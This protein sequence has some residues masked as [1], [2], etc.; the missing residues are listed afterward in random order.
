MSNE[1]TYV[2]ELNKVIDGLRQELPRVPGMIDGAAAAAKIAIFWDQGYVEGKR[3]EAY[4]KLDEL[5]AQAD[6]FVSACEEEC[7]MV[8]TVKSLREAADA[9][10][11]I[12]FSGLLG[13]LDVAA[14][15]GSRGDW[16]SSNQQLYEA[17][18]Q[19]LEGK[20]RELQTG[21]ASLIAA[22]RRC[23]STLQSHIVGGLMATGGLIL[24]LAGLVVAI[25]TG[26]TGIGA[27]IGLI[28]AIASFIFA[29]A[30]FFTLPDVTG[31]IR[32]QADAIKR[33]ASGID[34]TNWPPAP[35]LSAAGW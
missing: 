12:D 15:M 2:S 11:E 3:L 22:E 14:M 19:P 1:D 16:V 7:G 13:D 24:A 32:A 23:D 30:T 9:F 5:Q 27:V 25:A 4:A 26:W 28:I 29:L 20:V 34:E 33:A 8:V 17:K 35:Q 18:I 31:E 10:E 6:Q 21:L